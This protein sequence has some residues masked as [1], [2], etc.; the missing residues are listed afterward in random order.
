MI[1]AKIVG[2]SKS[3]ILA[4][5]KKMA[6][7]LK[8]VPRESINEFKDLTPIRSGNARSNTALKGD[9]I[10]ADYPYATVLDK[11]RHMTQRGMRGSKQ[12]PK[13]MTIPFFKW[14]HKRYKKIFGK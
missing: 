11:G 2:P 5:T 14:L 3:Q 4:K 1:T 13:G 7:E 10:V 6:A 12:A 9:T 8:K